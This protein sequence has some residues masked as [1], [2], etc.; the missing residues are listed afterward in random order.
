MQYT[1]NEILESAKRYKN[2]RDWLKNEPSIF[3][4]IRNRT[5]RD[6]NLL[7]DKCIEHMEY[8]FKPNGYWT[9][10]KCSNIVSQ[11]TIKSKFRKEQRFAY[12]S[13]LKNKWFDLLSH[14]EELAPS[15]NKIRYEKEFDTIEKCKEEA[16]KYETRSELLNGCSLLYKI[17]HRNNWG[18]ICFA[19]MKKVGNTS[20]RFIYV[21]EFKETKHAYVG[22]TCNIKKRKEEHLGINLRFKNVKS[23]VYQHMVENNIDPVFKILTKRPVKE[24][25]AEKSEDKWMRH[26]ENNG[27]KLLNIAKAGSLGSPRKRNLEYFQNIKDECSTLSEFI[28]KT[29]SH[30]KYRLKKEGLWNDLIQGLEIDV[31]YW[32][33]DNILKE[34]HKYKGYSRYR[35]QKEMSG[36]FK[37]VNRYNLIDELFPLKENILTYEYCKEI[38]LQYTTYSEFYK[39]SRSVRDKCVK[40][41]WFDLTSHMKRFVSTNKKP[42][43]SKY[44]IDIC[45]ELAKGYETRSQFEKEHSGAFKYLIKNNLV[46]EIFPPKKRVFKSKYTYEICEELSKECKTR[47]EFQ[48]KYSGAYKFLKNNGL[49]DT[50]YPKRNCLRVYD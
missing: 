23:N 18:D 33:K 27:W 13:I 37:A 12:K 39:N 21:F 16:L 2:Q 32:T 10:E 17:I 50:L 20:K 3:R 4:H 35:L 6:D 25:N 14:L 31:V 28:K 29:T 24:E 36:L 38:A 47:S 19:H 7:W 30:D 34:Y 15:G 8:I 43:Q 45:R 41:K 1:D 9:Y 48:E 11:Y 44:T 26:Y 22:L 49:L 5:Y 46:D 42:R 40:E